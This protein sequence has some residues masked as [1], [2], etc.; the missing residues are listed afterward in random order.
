LVVIDLADPLGPQVV[1]HTSLLEDGQVTAMAAAPGSLLLAGYAGSLGIYHP[2]CQGFLGVAPEP[3]HALSLRSYPNP[4][5]HRTMVRF[6]VR[7]HGSVETSIYDASGRRVR[8]LVRGPLD[9]GAH[10]IP[11][12]GRDDAGRRAPAGIYFVKVVTR[13]GAATSRLVKLD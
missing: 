4:C 3:A 12:D 2:Q 8:A 10:D 11:W 9:A 6:Q 5:L 7:D 13:D 1:S